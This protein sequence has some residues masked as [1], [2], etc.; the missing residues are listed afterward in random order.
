VH[1]PSHSVP[2]A[3]ADELF[4]G[5]VELNS[6]SVL[7]HNNYSIAG[8]IDSLAKYGNAPLEN[9]SLPYHVDGF[10]QG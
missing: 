7:I 1:P 2:T 4:R 10:G 6:S 3:H 8:S 5:A 9:A